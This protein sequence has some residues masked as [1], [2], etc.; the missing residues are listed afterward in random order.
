MSNYDNQKL[1]RKRKISQ[2]NKSGQLDPVEND[3]TDMEAKR[4][5]NRKSVEKVLNKNCFFYGEV[6]N[7]MHRCQTLELHQKIKDIAT[8][9]CNNEVLGKLS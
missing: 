9:M 7:D 8:K 5:S 1:A 2:V 6:S 4:R 3:I